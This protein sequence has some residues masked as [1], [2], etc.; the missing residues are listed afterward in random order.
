MYG[1]DSGVSI[2]TTWGNRVCVCIGSSQRMY[3]ENPLFWGSNRSEGL[4]QLCFGNTDSLT[5]S[6][7][8]PVPCSVETSL[9]TEQVDPVTSVRPGLPW[10]WVTRTA[11]SIPADCP[12]LPFFTWA[13]KAYRRRLNIFYVL[14]LCHGRTRRQALF[15]ASGS[16]C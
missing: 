6:S 12:R 9:L 3:R 7:A 10:Q 2:D 16:F 13:N 14:Q 1:W 11:R 4:K 15:R 8:A 5:R